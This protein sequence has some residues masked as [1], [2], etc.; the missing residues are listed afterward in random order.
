MI[1]IYHNPRC[2]KSREALD[3]VE[4]FIQT[5][6]LP[7]TVIDYQQTPLN[8]GQLQQLHLQ[9]GG[10]VRDMVRTNE[11]DYTALNLN[12]ASDEELLAALASYPRLLQRPIIVSRD[13]ALIARPPEL[14]RD[15]LAK[16][17]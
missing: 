5:A 9:I 15:W 4:Q 1:T 3:I 11:E 6:G 14:L 17:Q 7:L 13:R 2:S 16:V 8:L 12:Q 10:T